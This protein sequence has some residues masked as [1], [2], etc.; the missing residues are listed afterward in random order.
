MHMLSREKSRTFCCT[1]KSSG[2]VCH[3]SISHC[4][5][6]RSITLNK[7]ISKSYGCDSDQQL[8]P[9]DSCSLVPWSTVA[10]FNSLTSRLVAHVWIKIRLK[11][12]TQEPHARHLTVLFCSFAV[13]VSCIATHAIVF[14]PRYAGHCKVGVVSVRQRTLIQRRTNSYMLF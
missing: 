2:R 4:V 13:V 14:T 11:C 1:R 6:I 12:Y 3:I 5:I 8:I 7:K 10:N 9:S